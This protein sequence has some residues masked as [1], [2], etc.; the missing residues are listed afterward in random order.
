M[1]RQERKKKTGKKGEKVARSGGV[2][3]S[4]ANKFRALGG[5]V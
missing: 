2:C 3:Y 4:E 1:K 5:I